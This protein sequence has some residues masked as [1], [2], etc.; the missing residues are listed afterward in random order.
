MNDN[1]REVCKEVT[2]FCLEVLQI[3]ET[4]KDP[5]MVKAIAELLQVVSPL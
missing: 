5:A 2:K 1:E 4:K 3:P